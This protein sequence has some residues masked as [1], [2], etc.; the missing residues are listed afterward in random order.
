MDDKLKA[1]IS[2]NHGKRYQTHRK[3]LPLPDMYGKNL[4]FKTGGVDGCDCAE[5]LHLIEESKI[6]TTPLITHRF[7]LNEIEEAYR[8]FENKRDGVIKVAITGKES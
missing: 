4:T 5:I 3:F 1:D 8:I 2:K 6:D 7:P